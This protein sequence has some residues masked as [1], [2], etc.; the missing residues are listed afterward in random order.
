VSFSDESCSYTGTVTG[1]PPNRIA[2]PVSCQF[3]VESGQTITL[4]G[5]WA[6]SR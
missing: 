1:S 4:T 5:T 2:G 6:A 3:E